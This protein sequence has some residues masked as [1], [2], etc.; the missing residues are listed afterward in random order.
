ME[1]FHRFGGF[2]L[3]PWRNSIGGPG[4]LVPVICHSRSFYPACIQ[5][6]WTRSSLK[7]PSSNDFHIETEFS[8][9]LL[10]SFLYIP[11]DL[12]FQIPNIVEE[13]EPQDTASAPLQAAGTM[14]PAH[15]PAWP[16]LRLQHTPSKARGPHAC[17]SFLPCDCTGLLSQEGSVLNSLWLVLQNTV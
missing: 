12:N 9:H 5:Q 7:G 17:P 6:S 3:V 1:S 10:V 2:F 15:P 16:T 8:S 4:M 13:Q 11:D 14:P